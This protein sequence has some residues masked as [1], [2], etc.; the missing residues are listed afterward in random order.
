LAGSCLHH[1]VFVL[2]DAPVACQA[3]L[4]A[5]IDDLVLALVLSW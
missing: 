4:A 3:T 2:S 1:V 5:E